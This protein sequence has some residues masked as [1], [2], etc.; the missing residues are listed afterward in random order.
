MRN[1]LRVLLAM[2]EMTLN[3][4]SRLTGIS[5]S[6]LSGFYSHKAKNAELK[7]LTKIANALDVTLD[8]LIG[9]ENYRK[10]N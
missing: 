4:L 7:T 9:V 10:G 1:N 6:T 3:D 8:E 2:K 5:I